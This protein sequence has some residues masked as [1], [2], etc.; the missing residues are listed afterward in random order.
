MS[1]VAKASSSG[2]FK[3]LEEGTH[4]GTCF[5][6]IGVGLQETLWDP[7][8]KVY[9]GWEVPAVRVQFERNGEEFDQ[10]IVI[11]QDYTISLSSKANLRH[12]LEGWRG[13]AFTKQ[14]LDGFELFNLISKPCLLTIVH[15]ESGG[16]TFA[17][18][19]S[20]CKVMKGQEVPPQEMDI[21][22]YSQDA[23]E[24]WDQLPDWLQQKIRNQVEVESE[25][26]EETDSEGAI[27]PDI[28][29]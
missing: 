20:I 3:I 27:D 10:P 8:E 17:N 5:A 29:F 9:I 2:N 12:I 25:I 16:R 14:E 1:L 21:L 4:L 6:V 28:P 22:K 15:N 23:I 24:Q 19:Q 13:R 18:V 26:P 7:K 11:W